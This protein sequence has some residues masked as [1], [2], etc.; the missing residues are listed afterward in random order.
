MNALY[1]DPGTGSMLFSIFIGLAAAS[2]FLFR[3]L[4]I[5]LKFIF[6][7]KKSGTAKRRQIVIYNE[8]RHY[9]NVFCPVLDALERRAQSA[10]YLTSA[11]D[12]PFFSRR[13]E[14]ITGEYIG[15]GNKAFTRLNFL[16][17][18]ICLMTTPGLE[19]YQLKRSKS[20]RHYAH[21]LHD[22]GDVTCYRLFGIDWFDSI[23]LSG[24][25]QAADIRTLEEIRGTP[26]KQLPVVGSTYLDVYNE[27]LR[28]LPGKDNQCTV[29]ISPSWGP[30]T[31]LN[32]FGEKLI[33]P[34]IATG[35]RIIIRPHPQSVKH[36]KQV[37]DRL[38]EKYKEVSAV[39]WDYSP[40]NLTT[41][42]QS[43]IMISDFSGIIFD[44]VFLFNRPVLYHNTGFNM[45]IYDAGDLDH[46]PWKFEALG[47]FGVTLD[48][49]SFDHIGEVITSCLASKLLDDARRQAKNTAWQHIGASGE[50]TADFLMATL[51]GFADA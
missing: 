28:E 21:I 5:K 23:L 36:E 29:L 47:H 17:A 16:D 37:L 32:R 49:S 38:N 25:Y 51:K 12:D 35:R 24:E 22:T 39:S 43:D 18:D 50:R 48:E 19:V 1:I 20:V 15:E 41:L 46:K 45:E 11:A 40:E 4:L 9:W 10:H 27:K 3:T 33:D 6:T 34:L 2:Y 30:G 14:F 31:L 8:G 26:V 7:G 44:Y 13:Y 42:S